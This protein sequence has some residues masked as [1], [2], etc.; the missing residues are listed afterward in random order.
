[1]NK[2][3]TIFSFLLVLFIQW[4]NGQEAVWTLQQ[5]IDVGLE[6]NIA[7]KIQQLEVKRMQK[8]RVS[9]LNELLPAVNL[10]GSQ[11]YNFG[12]TIDPGTNARVS[13]NIQFDN[14]YLSANM[15][16]LDFSAI[17]N[18]QKGKIA[19][20]IAKAD[21]EVIENEYKLQI[22]ESFYQALFTQ[23]LVKIQVEQLENGKFNLDRIS[24][25]VTIGSRPKSDLY[26]I[27]LTYSQEQKRVLETKQLLENQKTQLFQ[28][29]NYS[30]D[31]IETTVLVNT[32]IAIEINEAEVSSP[33]IKA[34]ELGFERSKMEIKR[35]RANNL[36]T[37][38]SFYQLSSFYFK[39]I[40]Q[41]EVMVDNFSD[42]IGNNKNQQVGIQLAIPVFNGFKNNRMITVAKIET[43]QSKLKIELEKNNINQQLS[44]ELK[45][46]Q[47][48]LSLQDKLAQVEGFATA[49]F[50][51][52]QAKFSSGT[53]DVFSYSMSKNNLLTSQ[54]DVLKNE[55]QIQ[56]T[57]YKMNL[58]GRNSL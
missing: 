30:Q 8:A 22:L 36:P 11:S 57:A 58:I 42:Q 41:P 55:L 25:E 47:N 10:F 44:L 46:K 12:S 15:N 48:F 38:S 19:I 9:M 2:L 33:K 51:T 4:M 43:E 5:C 27:Q 16:L 3:K 6:N 20:Q 24:K 18:A 1:M 26:D 23:E 34:A 13:S 52:T 45:N 39:P 49:S 56:F 31:D 54:Y 32:I 37:L 21:Q 7:I 29:L 35:Q 17:A 53:V 40:N 50:T 14:F 28:L